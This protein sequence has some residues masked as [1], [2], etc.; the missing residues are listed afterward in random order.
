MLQQAIG[1]AAGR[2]ADIK[3]NL[4]PHI[5]LPVFQCS[6]ELQPASADILQVLAQQAKLR[7]IAYRRARFFDLLAINQYFSGEDERL[8]ALPRGHH[9]PF[10]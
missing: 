4:A 7:I 1:E 3:A 2:G 8:R 6:F 5:H 10:E 9:A